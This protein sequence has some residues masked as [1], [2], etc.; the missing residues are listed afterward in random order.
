MSL[1][2]KYDEVDLLPDPERI[3]EGLRDTGYDFNTAIADIVDNSIAAKASR[4]DIK[5][6]LDPTNH[7]IVSIA[8]NGC[9]MN[10]E[11]LKNAMKYGS[12][13]REDPS[14]L[15]KFGL[16][17]KTASTAFC[18]CL[19]VISRGG[20]DSTVEKV[21]W[22]LNYIAKVNQ[23]KL[24]VLKPLEDEIEVLDFTAQG[25]TGTLV[26]WEQ[27][28]RL[29]SREYKSKSTA[30]QALNKIVAQLRFH[31]SL[32]YQHFLNDNGTI[33]T[34]NNILIEP[35]DPFCKDEP[36]TQLL[37]NEEID[38]EMPDGTCAKFKLTAYMIPRV[39]EYSSKSAEQK[40]RLENSMQGFYVYRENRLIHYGNWLGMYKMEPHGSLLRAELCFDHT[41]DT[42]F[43]IDIKKSRIMLNQ[44]LY[45]YIKD[46]FLPAPRRAAD[47]R[48]RKGTNS[49]IFKDSESAHEASD[50]NIDSKASGVEQ[51]DV[52]VIDQNSNEVE[53][54]NKQG[55]FRNRLV[56]KSTENNREVRII[57]ME[58]IDDG[59]LWEPCINNG[60]HAVS[61][62]TSHPYYQKVYYPVLDQNVMVTGMDALLWALAEGELA[63]YNSET[64]E[65]YED[66][67][68]QV[69]RI[70]KK[71]LSDLPDPDVSKVY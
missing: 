49:R 59:I 25:G 57:P 19:S 71:L 47:E 7:T 66:M 33:I 46:Q 35:W 64:K 55:T 9:G 12:E 62:N 29:F 48:Y 21:Q 6:E 58:S 15:G 53:I 14:S 41:M 31:V 26:V 50:K 13:R 54:K 56:I 4:I 1:E 51:A 11:E 23:W 30:Q 36:N 16:G 63:T 17:L 52:R 68:H 2:K 22:D 5:I 27:I 67:R 18:R 69:S 70:L 43:S 32:V 44:D 38:V 3:I 45:D 65:Q 60:K 28:D 40:S 61:I 39:D 34:I 20:I 42:A 8:D 37:A 10:F 24:K